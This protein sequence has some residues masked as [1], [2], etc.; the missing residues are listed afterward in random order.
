[1]IFGHP[2]VSLDD[3]ADAN[4]IIRTDRAAAVS[5][6][7]ARNMRWTAIRAQGA[8]GGGWLAV[9]ADLPLPSMGPLAGMIRCQW[10]KVT[11]E[12]VEGGIILD[13]HA[14]NCTEFHGPHRHHRCHTLRHP[15]SASGL[16]SSR[17]ITRVRRCRR[18]R[19]QTQHNCRCGKTVTENSNRRSASAQCGSGSRFR[20]P[21]RR[22]NL[23]VITNARARTHS[24]RAA[25][26]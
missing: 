24:L 23:L 16:S 21:T 18:W 6:R 4:F 3:F 13:T 22:K 7:R 8:D 25:A 14:L 10:R 19:T 20:Q 9:E 15:C 26:G 12:K 11:S 17:R 1:L 2:R 5:R